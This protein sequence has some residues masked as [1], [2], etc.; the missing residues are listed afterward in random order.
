MA[1]QISC[2]CGYVIRA[3][4]DEQVVAQ[5]EAHIASDHPDLVGKVS[6][7]DLLSWVEEV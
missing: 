1:K 5:A 3:E 2:E 4:S 6:R 7:D